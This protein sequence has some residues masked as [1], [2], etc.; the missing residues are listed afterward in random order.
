VQS[1]PPF[2]VIGAE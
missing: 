1:S 2:S